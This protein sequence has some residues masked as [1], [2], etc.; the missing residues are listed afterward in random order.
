MK[1]FTTKAIHGQFSKKDVHGSLRMPIYDSV[2]FEFQSSRDIQLAFEGKK[3]SHAYSRISNPT[4]EDFEQKVR[5]LADAAGV[6][7]VSSG[8]AGISSLFLSIAEAGSNIITTRFLFGN[9]ISFLEKTLGSWGLEVRY[10]DMDQP[11]TLRGVIDENTRAIFLEIVTNPQLQV[12][13]IEALAATAREFKVPLILD[14][15]LTT[16]YLF[17][18]KDYGVAVEVLSSTKYISG[19]ATSVG[20]L[21][22]DLG[23]FDWKYCPKLADEARRTGPFALMTKLRQ[24]VY[25][26]LGCCMSPD[27]AYL[28][29]LGLETL[30]LRIEKSSQNSLK[31]ARFLQ[32]QPEVLSVNYPGLKNSPYYQ[33]AKKQF[34]GRFG[35]LL[36]FRL[37]DKDA[38]FRF[39]DALKIIRR[40]TNLN[41][42]K[43]LILHPASTIFCE[44]S[45]EERKKMRIEENMLRLSVGIEDVEDIFD[46]LSRGLKAI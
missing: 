39:M 41:D 35:G 24:E 1:G 6:L 32:E 44:Y 4:V 34:G 9:T 16:P 20:G 11:Q 17:K 18:A 37:S 30:G 29:A 31:I 27:T 13:D 28:Q 45:E 33:T 26:N 22:I 36:T 19:G 42:N 21:I 43:T 7:A 8:M 2:S 38:C 46:D 23:N 3:P 14:S 15:T 10:V 25:R 12:A 40:S 5:L